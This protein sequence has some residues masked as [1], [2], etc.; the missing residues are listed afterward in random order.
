M[1]ASLLPHATATNTPANTANAQP[2]AIT[3]QPLPSAF[4]RFRS[5]PA[6]TPSPSKISTSVPAN[7][8]KTGDVIS[9]SSL[10]NAAALSEKPE[11]SRR[12][13]KRPCHGLFPFLVHTVARRI[14]HLRLPRLVH[15]PVGAQ[16]IE[17]FVESDRKSCCVR[18]S[19]R[20][21]LLD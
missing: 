6:T 2:V 4:D 16:L 15:S 14:L 18:R 10:F 7:S 3:I 8:P 17:V 11:T 1:N 20:R 12:P 5:T 21:G 19:E 9:F 13:V